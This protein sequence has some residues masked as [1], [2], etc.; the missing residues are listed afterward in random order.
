MK[1]AKV[2][3]TNDNKIE[4]KIKQKKEKEVKTNIRRTTDVTTLVTDEK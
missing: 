4:K 1:H 2:E 3:R